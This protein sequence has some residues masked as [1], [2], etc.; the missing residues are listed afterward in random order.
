MFSH[1]LLVISVKSADAAVGAHTPP[2]ILTRPDGQLSQKV[3][4]YS[5]C[6]SNPW[7]FCLLRDI[8]IALSAELETCLI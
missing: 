7:E 2:I 4:P 8:A 1:V 5:S 3:S 6:L